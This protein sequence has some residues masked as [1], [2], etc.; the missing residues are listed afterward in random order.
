MPIVFTNTGST[1]CG[2]EGYPGVSFVNSGGQ[3]I[4]AAAVRG[5]GGT[6]G[7]VQLTL[8]AGGSASAALQIA[9]PGAMSCK[10]ETPSS[11]RVYPPNETKSVDVPYKSYAACQDKSIRQLHIQPVVSGS[12]S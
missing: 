2:I 9:D 4:G 11:L 7:P 10:T 12:G 6:Q 5:S 8:P 3:Q 1:P